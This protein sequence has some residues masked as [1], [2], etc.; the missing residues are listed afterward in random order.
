MLRDIYEYWT[1]RQDYSSEPIY[2]L[3]RELLK[4]DIGE[5]VTEA[6]MIFLAA[7]YRYNDNENPPS[8]IE[9]ATLIETMTGAIAILGEDFDRFAFVDSLNALK[10]GM[11][12][13]RTIVSPRQDA[14]ISY[15]GFWD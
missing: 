8:S 14:N 12:S 9:E 11:S 1:V 6:L 10:E 5:P 2:I 13:G 4:Q 7:H 15:H 3:D